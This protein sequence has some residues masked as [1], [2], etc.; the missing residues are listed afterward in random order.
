[1]GMRCFSI[2]CQ[3][4]S[5]TILPVLIEQFKVLLESFGVTVFVRGVNLH[6][7]EQ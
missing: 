2:S 4:M 1:M 7:G 6:F 5:C 3:V